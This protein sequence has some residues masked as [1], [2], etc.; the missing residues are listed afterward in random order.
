[1]IIWNTEVNAPCCPGEIVNDNGDSI[2]IQTDW[3]YP[4]TANT[5]GW[6]LREVQREGGDCD[7]SGTDGTVDCHECGVSASDFISAASDWLYDNDGVVA[8]D[9]GYFE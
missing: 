7:H 2:L 8:E 9:P 3:D 6:S 5:F 4:G 1:M